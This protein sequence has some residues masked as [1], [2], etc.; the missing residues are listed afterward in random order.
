MLSF[1]DRLDVEH[2]LP[3]IFHII[4]LLC[5]T[6]APC[7]RAAAHGIIINVTQ[8][9]CTSV[10]VDEEAVWHLRLSLAE[11]NEPKFIVQVH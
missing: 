9:L 11:M 6:G 4:T 8:S 10:A 7:I 1:N 3:S 5:A 2:N